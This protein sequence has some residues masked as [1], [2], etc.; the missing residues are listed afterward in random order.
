MNIESVVRISRLSL[1]MFVQYLIWG[2]W[3]PTLGNYMVVIG[4]GE[5]ISLAYAL[6]PLGLH[7]RTLL[8]GHGGGPVL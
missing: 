5:W 1:M 7:C 6:G 4:K 3:A 2:A 8:H